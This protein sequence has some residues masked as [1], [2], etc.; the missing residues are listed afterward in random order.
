[1]FFSW[2]LLPLERLL[3][4]LS[5]TSTIYEY[6]SF[7]CSTNDDGPLNV[8][9]IVPHVTLVPVIAYVIPPPPT[10]NRWIQP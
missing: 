5:S 4:L 8:L 9:P 2:L 7:S 10:Y 1:M 3:L 6:L